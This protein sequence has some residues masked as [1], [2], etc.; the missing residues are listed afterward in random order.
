MTSTN[1]AVLSADIRTLFPDGVAAAELRVPGDV[2]LLLPAEAAGLGRA[3]QKRVEEFAAG[4]LCA[5][6]AL[7]QFGIE[8]FA[9][10]VRSDRQPAWP[11]SMV[12]SITHTGG[13]CAAVAAERRSFAGLGVD[14]EIVG[15]VKPDLW[16]T[17]CAGSEITWLRSLP[18]AEQVPAAALI[19]AAKEAF[20]KCQYAVTGEFLSFHDVLIETS[21]WGAREAAFSAHATR[22]LALT[23]FA[24]LPV[25]GRF[26]FHEGYVSA[27]AALPAGAAFGS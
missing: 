7:A 17:I 16:A 13:L 19:F 9:L 26:R 4:R 1:P 10:L 18:A 23:K 11:E 14:T 2:S 3:V 24:A 6:R 21:E 12:G 22:E 25:F 27:G 15:A 5:R 8:D 20:Y